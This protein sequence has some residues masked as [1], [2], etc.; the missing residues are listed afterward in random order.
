[1]T[2]GKDSVLIFS[3]KHGLSLDDLRERK[4]FCSRQQINW[5]GIV[6]WLW[7]ERLSDIGSVGDNRRKI[8]N[9]RCQQN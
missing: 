8:T 1:M 7:I 4:H 6:D 3:A 2:R 9:K 5:L